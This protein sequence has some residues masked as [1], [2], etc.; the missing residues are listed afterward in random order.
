MRIC[1]DCIDLIKKIINKETIV[2][3]KMPGNMRKKGDV[4]ND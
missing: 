1:N 4:V 3:M 2:A